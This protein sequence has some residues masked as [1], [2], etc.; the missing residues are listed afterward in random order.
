M[1][2][3]QTYRINK[4]IK[5]LGLASR[6][7]ADELIEAGL[8]TING[9][10]AKLG[11]KVSEEDKVEILTSKINKNIKTKTGKTIN[12]GSK[13]YII[14]YKPKDVVSHSPQYGEK[15]VKDFFPDFESD[16]LVIIGRLDKHSEGMMLLSNDKRLV[17]KILDPKFDHEKEYLVQVQEKLSSNIERLFKKGFEVKDRFIAKPAKVELLDSYNFSITLTEG[18]KHQIRL[19]TNDLHYTVSKLKRIRIMNL[20]MGNLKIGESKNVS[21]PALKELMKSIGLS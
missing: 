12:I 18:K 20:N 15:E 14:F 10:I 3:I 4:R 21:G 9:K 1:T 6:R 11:D 16:R 13:K 5:D 19:M 2:E 7:E 8:I 17:E